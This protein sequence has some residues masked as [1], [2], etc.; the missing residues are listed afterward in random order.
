MKPS[1][2]H[3]VTYS[4]TPSSGKMPMALIMKIVTEVHYA[5]A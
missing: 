5:H 2:L 4:V 3:T 1:V